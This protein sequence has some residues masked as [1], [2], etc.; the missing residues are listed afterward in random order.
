MRFAAEAVSCRAWPGPGRGQG[1][2]EDGLPVG[3]PGV[4]LPWRHTARDD[5]AEVVSRALE[6]AHVSLWISQRD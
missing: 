5:L 2:L 3:L 4:A 6:P 1:L